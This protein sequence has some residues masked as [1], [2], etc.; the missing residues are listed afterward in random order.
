MQNIYNLIVG[1]KNEQQQEK[2]VLD[3]TVQSVNTDQDPNRLPDGTKEAMILKSFQSAPQ[4]L[5]VPGYKAYV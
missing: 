5:I 3:A 4:P 2:A 1:Q